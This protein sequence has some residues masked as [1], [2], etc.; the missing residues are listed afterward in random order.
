M[1]KATRWLVGLVAVLVVANIALVATIWLKK[2]GAGKQLP[3]RGNARDYLVKSLSLN[4]AQVQAFDSS[5]QGHFER[6]KQYKD[7]LHSVKDRFFDLLSDSRPDST[8]ERLK[9]A[10]QEKAGELQGKLD[11]ETFNHFYQLRSTLNPSQKQKFDST[12]Q[13]VLRTM[14]PAGPHPPRPGA[15]MQNPDDRMGPP[16][17][18][19][20]H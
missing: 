9:L 20:M 17:D 1:N 8:K 10:L 3:F 14:A 19:P 12:I 13:E 4:E 6:V 7:Q 15:G 18:E 5:R 16:P 2:D 11:A